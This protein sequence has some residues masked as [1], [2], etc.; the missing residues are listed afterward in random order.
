[1]PV[2]PVYRG[3]GRALARVL[4]EAHPQFPAVLMPAVVDGGDQA[5]P[6]ELVDEVL[7]LDVPVDARDVEDGVGIPPLDA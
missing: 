6:H 2:Q 7:L 4:H 5:I 1:M 3:H